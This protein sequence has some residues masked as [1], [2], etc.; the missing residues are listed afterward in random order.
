MVEGS[1]NM[2]I[3]SAVLVLI[4]NLVILDY[5][6]RINIPVSSLIPVSL[7]SSVVAIMWFNDL[8]LYQLL[9]RL[10]FSR[11]TSNISQSESNHVSSEIIKSELPSEYV[12][13]IPVEIRPIVVGGLGVIKEAMNLLSNPNIFNPNTRPSLTKPS[14]DEIKTLTMSV[15]EVD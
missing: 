11:P 8:S 13:S 5:W 7:L 1:K 15:E 4:L 10:I 3:G 12:E 2:K 6:F 14:E 9:A